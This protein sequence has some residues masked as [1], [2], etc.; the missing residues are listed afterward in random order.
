MA[1]S[2]GHCIIAFT[3]L[4][5]DMRRRELIVVRLQKKGLAGSSVAQDMPTKLN[6]KERESRNVHA[7]NVHAHEHFAPRHRRVNFILAA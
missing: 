7:V 5:L 2:C 1:C 6:P 4:V 3:P